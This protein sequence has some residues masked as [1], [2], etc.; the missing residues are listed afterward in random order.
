MAVSDQGLGKQQRL[1]RSR[2]FDEAYAQGR[3]YVGRHFLL[4]LR[5][6]EGASLRVGVVTSRKV[7]NAVAR[8]RA[9]R[10]LRA[11]WRQHRS[12]FHGSFD[13]VLVSRATLPG[14]P[15]EE[16]REDFMRL[17]RKAGL[18]A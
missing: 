3:K 6:G 2:L 16:L 13:V 10:R 8:N 1:V 4:W 15:W 17:T 12:A 18:H 14:A 9:R 11:L 7:G 5:A